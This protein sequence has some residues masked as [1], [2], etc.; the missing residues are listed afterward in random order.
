MEPF[1][2]NR[3]FLNETGVDVRLKNAVSDFMRSLI[4]QIKR[5]KREDRRLPTSIVKASE[6]DQETLSILTTNSVV[7]FIVRI[8][9]I[10]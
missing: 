6:L 8:R 7:I 4:G 5:Q 9:L 1:T 3:N 10:V 2:Q